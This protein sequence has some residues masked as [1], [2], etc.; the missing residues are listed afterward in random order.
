M[1]ARQPVD[2]LQRRPSS[3][4]GSAQSWDARAAAVRPGHRKREHRACGQPPGLR[5]GSTPTRHLSPRSCRR[6]DRRERC[7]ALHLIQPWGRDAEGCARWPSGRLCIGAIGQ[8]GDLAV[9]SRWSQFRA[10]EPL[11]R[12]QRQ[13]A[14]MVSGWPANRVRRSVPRQAA[15]LP[16][17]PKWRTAETIRDRNAE[18]GIPGVVRIIEVFREIKSEHFSKSNCHIRVS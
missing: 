16:R 6:H 13:F 11:R 7:D 2:R 12:P 15:G 4:A 14:A 18:C 17:Q 9:R 5:T 8:L 1:D 3:L 10:T